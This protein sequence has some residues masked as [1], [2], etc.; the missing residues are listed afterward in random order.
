[1]VRELG[2]GGG[3]R[4]NKE[5]LGGAVGPSRHPGLCA[6]LISLRAQR[7]RGLSSVVLGAHPKARIGSKG[8]LMVLAIRIAILI[9]LS[10]F[11]SKGVGIIKGGKKEK[12][13]FRC[14]AKQI[15]FAVLLQDPIINLIPFLLRALF[16]F[17]VFPFPHQA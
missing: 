16:L 17:F 5:R 11:W 3:A 9:A 2:G 7:P 15:H 12:T 8:K 4:R 6:D 1:M 14:C 10:V 13:P